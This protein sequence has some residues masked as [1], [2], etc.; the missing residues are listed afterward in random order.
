MNELLQSN[1][2]MAEP[3]A[4]AIRAQ[5]LTKAYGDE[6]QALAGISFVV[7]QGEI[8]GLL[9]PNGAGKS[10]TVRILVTLTQPDEGCAEV[11]GHDVVHES[12]K[13]RRQIGYVAQASGVDKYAT[14]REN[15][16]L[17]AQLQRLPR[18]LIPGRVSSLLEWI[19]LNKAANRIVHTYSGG[20]R[21]RLDIAMGL[22]H[23]P[24]VLFLDE[25]TTGL[26]PETRSALWHD[27]IR[28]RQEQ[29]LTVLLTTHY[30][31]EADRLCDR[32]A[33]IDHG[34][35]VVQ[36]TPAELKAQIQ[37]D[38]ITLEV[39]SQDKHVPELLRPLESVLEIIA[40]GSSI[41]A[42]VDKGASALPGLITALERAGVNV[43][44]ATL[45][46]PSLDDVYLY[47]TGHRFVTDGEAARPYSPAGAQP[48]GDSQ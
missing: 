15:L 12:N 36:G 31:E 29:Q 30:L 20:M 4:V 9:G 2:S 42:R 3:P 5:G 28:L 14:G 33:I 47:H 43:R 46:Q 38:M 26:D 17:Q 34:Q 21:R 44:A 18:S 13:V 25:P 41:I 40:N 35:I 23:E 45:S 37:G 27:L 22:V 10:T 19:G 8:F 24:A 11:A 39:N 7:R 32:L 1:P 48:Y 16:T 6:V